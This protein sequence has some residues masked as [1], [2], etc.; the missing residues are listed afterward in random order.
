MERA[1]LFCSDRGGYR[2]EKGVVNEKYL[3]IFIGANQS[4]KPHE[5]SDV[6]RNRVPLRRAI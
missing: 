4:W 1:F 2:I 5:T 6:R 3:G